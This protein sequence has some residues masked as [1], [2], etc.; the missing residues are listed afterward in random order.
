MSKCSCSTTKHGYSKLCRFHWNEANIETELSRARQWEI[1]F[2]PLNPED[3]ADKQVLKFYKELC[4]WAAKGI[5][6]S[7][8]VGSIYSAADKRM[9]SSP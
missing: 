4:Y 1:G 9:N 3:P 7:G 2:K 6:E 5:G 8:S